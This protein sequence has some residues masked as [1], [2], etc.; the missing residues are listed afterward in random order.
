MFDAKS[1]TFNEYFNMTL[2]RVNFSM[3]FDEPKQ[4]VYGVD[5]GK[6][7]RIELPKRSGEIFHDSNNDRYVTFLYTPDKQKAIDILLNHVITKTDI[8]ICYHERELYEARERH[9]ALLKTKEEL[10]PQEN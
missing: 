6:K 3:N 8:D 2:D 1:N 4:H 7:M 10:S 9:E 5:Y